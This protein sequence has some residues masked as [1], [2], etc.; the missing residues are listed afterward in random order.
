MKHKIAF[1]EWEKECEDGAC[2]EYG[3]KLFVDGKKV[4]DSVTPVKAVRAVLNEL[5]I[6]YEIEQKYDD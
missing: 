2:C 6:E 3:T 4:L 1:V 5:G